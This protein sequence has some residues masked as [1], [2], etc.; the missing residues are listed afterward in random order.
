MLLEGK[1]A[2][3]YGAGAIGGAAARGFAREGAAVFIANRTGAKAEELAAAIRDEGGR[4][5]AAEVDVL[6]AAQ[7]DEFVASDRARTMTAATVNVSAGA[8]LDF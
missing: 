5:T 4:A 2:L 3:V 1:N 8:L 7:V 6:D